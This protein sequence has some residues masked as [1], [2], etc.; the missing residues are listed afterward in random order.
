[1]VIL[2]LGR[3]Q[4]EVVHLW[5]PVVWERKSHKFYALQ[6]SSIILYLKYAVHRWINFIGKCY[7]YISSSLERAIAIYEKFK[8]ST[9]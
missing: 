5:L 1:M 7:I 4:Q 8:F 6:A 9:N 3:T 2:V